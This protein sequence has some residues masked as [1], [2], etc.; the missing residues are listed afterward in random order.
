MNCRKIS[1]CFILA[2]LLIITG[3]GAKTPIT[4]SPL[5][6]PVETRQRS[7]EFFEEYES[8]YKELSKQ[9]TVIDNA[10]DEGDTEQEEDHPTE[11]Y[12]ATD[13]TIEGRNNMEWFEAGLKAAAAEQWEQAFIAFNKAIWLDS[14]NAEA[15]FHRGNIHDERGHY[16]KAIADYNRAIRLNPTYVDAYLR[17]GF[18]YNNIGKLR[19][20]LENIKKAAKLGDSTAQKFLKDKGIP[21]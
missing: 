15:Y 4:Y 3:C 16:D 8:L 20:A 13:N 1:R 12:Q 17:R 21:W 19:K 7:N 14:N 18:A 9:T 11:F 10:E 2:T 6:Q 5:L